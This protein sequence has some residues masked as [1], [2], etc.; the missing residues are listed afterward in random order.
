LPEDF[1]K[2]NGRERKIIIN[3]PYAVNDF[4]PDSSGFP[5]KAAVSHATLARGK[6]DARRDK[7]R[8]NV[9]SKGLSHKHWAKAARKG[10]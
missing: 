9:L 7:G 8:F 4:Q 5:P 1:I 3:S 6:G 10:R 2:W